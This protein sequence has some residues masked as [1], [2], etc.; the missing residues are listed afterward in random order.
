MQYYFG[1]PITCFYSDIHYSS[2]MLAAQETEV[3]LKTRY[4][5]KCRNI[6][7]IGDWLFMFSSTRTAPSS[8]HWTTILRLSCCQ[9]QYGYIKNCTWTQHRPS[10]VS[11]SQAFKMEK[12]THTIIS[13]FR[14]MKCL[15]E[16]MIEANYLH[17][18]SCA[19][20]LGRNTSRRYWDSDD[21]GFNPSTLNPHH[22]IS[23][24]QQDANTPD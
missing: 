5:R 1:D 20:N 24:A 8:K 10:I 23:H 19:S 15:T 3:N 7:R 9:L 21:V 14:I 6:C 17:L 13:W 11:F 2:P 18:Y 22:L 16:K 4:F 12:I